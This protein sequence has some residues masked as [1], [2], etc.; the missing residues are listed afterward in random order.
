MAGTQ[1][2]GV[3]QVPPLQHDKDGEEHR[4]L[5]L[6]DSCNALE[7]PQQ[8]EGDCE[9]QTADDADAVH[10]GGCDDKRVATARL[11][12]HHLTR[13]R[14]RGQCHCG[15]GVHDEVHPEYLRDGQRQFGT[16]EGTAEHQQQGSH[17]DHE[18]EEDETLDVLIERAAPHD[19]LN[20]GAERVVDE[21]D[22]A[23]FLGNTGA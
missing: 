12:L 17:V 3:E 14:Q 11:L 5:H 8:R 13:R 1:H 6:V 9:E 4:Q 16:N 22:V 10:H 2:A 18:L 15:K 7:I 19:R 20:D 21:R 23:G